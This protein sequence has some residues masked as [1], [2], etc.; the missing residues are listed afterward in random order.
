MRH[1]FKKKKKK[2][3]GLYWNSMDDQ[4]DLGLILTSGEDFLD[5]DWSFSWWT[6][7]KMLQ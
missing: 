7:S 6:M 2:P 4:E 3:A 1:G 5:R